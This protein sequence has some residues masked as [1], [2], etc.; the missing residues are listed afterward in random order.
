MEHFLDYISWDYFLV[1]ALCFAA[2]IYGIVAVF[3][4][5]SDDDDDSDDDG[6]MGDDWDD[7]ILDL[8]DG[9]ITMDELE[10]DLSAAG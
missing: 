1:A 10:R 5:I 8:P 6:G 9:V 3:N 2:T 4:D 7:P